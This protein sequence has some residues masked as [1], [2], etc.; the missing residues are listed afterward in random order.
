MTTSVYAEKASNK[1]QYS[2]RIYQGDSLIDK[3]YLQKNLQQA[4]ITPTH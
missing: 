1:I 3:E 4:Y 2:L